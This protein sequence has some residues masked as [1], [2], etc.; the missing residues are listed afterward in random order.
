MIIYFMSIS[1]GIFAATFL[2]FITFNSGF[3]MEYEEVDEM[4]FYMGRRAWDMFSMYIVW[5]YNF[6]DFT[7]VPIEFY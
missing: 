7:G 3:I 4:E 2:E 1:Y 6:R 5:E